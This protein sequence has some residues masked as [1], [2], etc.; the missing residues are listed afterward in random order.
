MYT[1]E[2]ETSIQFTCSLNVPTE[3]IKHIKYFTKKTALVINGSVQVEGT[4][5][6]SSMEGEDKI[7]VIRLN[8]ES[9]LHTEVRCVVISTEVNYTSNAKKI[10]DIQEYHEVNLTASRTKLTAGQSVTLT[11]TAENKRGLHLI[12]WYVNGETISQSS[13]FEGR[14]QE[15][16][17]DAPPSSIMTC[18]TT[19]DLNVRQEYKFEC[20]TRDNSVMEQPT[21]SI[22]TVSVLVFHVDKRLII[23]LSAPVAAFVCVVVLVTLIVRVRRR[24]LQNTVIVSS[25]KA[26]HVSFIVPV[27]SNMYMGD[28]RD[29][30]GREEGLTKVERVREIID[31]LSNKHPSWEKNRQ[32]LLI[33]EQI[34]VGNFGFVFSGKMPDEHGC[35]QTVAIKTIKEHGLDTAALLEFEKEMEIMTTLRHK[36][37]VNL[38]GI[39][40]TSLPFYII[41]ELLEHGQLNT[42]LHEFAPSKEKPVGGLS[43]LQLAWMCQQPCDAL[44]YISTKHLVHRDVSARNCLVGEKLLVKLADFGLSRDTAKNN[45][46]SYYKK[47][48]G[49]VPVSWT[50]PEAL[51]YGKYTTS[52]DVWGFG[53]LCW[54]VFSFGAQPFAHLN[55]QQV[56]VSVCRG[57]RM[58]KPEL[59]PEPLWDVLTKC[60]VD[61]PDDRIMFSALLAFFQENYKERN[62]CSLKDKHN[63]MQ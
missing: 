48:G 18:N 15:M 59:C 37:I 3:C 14:C 39:C 33:G 29:K 32:S 43:V 13:V 55:N 21:S 11:C 62:H 36:Y 16:L 54:E 23:W 1:Y 50:A 10:P 31:G 57:E 46:K 24:K 41:M 44:E 19:E 28:S 25:L 49:M 52:N 7:F 34:G 22:V 63:L 35:I 4:E 58:E 38:L 27:S 61:A 40:T 26:D 47:E 56:M 6:S 60:W 45:A 42:Y 12:E 51:T 2:E 17:R 30:T 5:V 8:Y 20:S 9:H 53:V